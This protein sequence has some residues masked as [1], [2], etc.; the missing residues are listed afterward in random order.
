MGRLKRM[1]R[2]Q[3]IYGRINEQHKPDEAVTDRPAGRVE[4]FGRGRIRD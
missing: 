2:V 1:S 3:C 4:M